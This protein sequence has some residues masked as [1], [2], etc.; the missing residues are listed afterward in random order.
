MDA[1]KPDRGCR[2]LA[3][4]LGGYAVT[5]DEHWQDVYRRKLGEQDCARLAVAAPPAHGALYVCDQ[6]QVAWRLLW[7][8]EE[9][10]GIRQRYRELMTEVADLVTARLPAYQQFE[11]GEHGRL[12][13]ASE[14]DW[15][16]GCVPT[17]QGENLG[18]QYNA[19]L[20]QLA[21]VSLF[22]HEYVQS[23]YEAAHVLSLSEHPDH[24]SLP[25]HHLPAMMGTY[26][27]EN[28]ALSWSFYDIEWMYW[29][30]VERGL[31]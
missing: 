14:W 8:L 24:H 21:P 22:E 9:T 15:R 26:P 3:A 25:M 5:G 11:A 31:A 23:P 28:L 30:M 13:A 12:M 10:A 18:E 1:I 2:L 17:E 19:R 7:E 16:Q 27:Y 6:N 20:R 4:L 29:L